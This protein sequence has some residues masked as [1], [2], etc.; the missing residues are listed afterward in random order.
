MFKKKEKTEKIEK[1][2]KTEKKK[3]KGQ[4][5]EIFGKIIAAFMVFFMLMAVFATP[6]YYLLYQQ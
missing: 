4:K 2:E 1:V 3:M 5:G 6:I